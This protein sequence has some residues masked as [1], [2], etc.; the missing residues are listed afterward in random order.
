MLFRSLVQD[1]RVAWWRAA[2]AQRLHGEVVDAMRLADDALADARQ[3]EN[4]KLRSPLDSLRYQR[5]LTENLRL[6]ESI[7]NELATARF[8][9]AALINTP[10]VQSLALDTDEQPG[11]GEFLGQ[12]AQALEEMALA[13][14]ADLREQLYLRRIAATEARKVVAR[15]YPNLT[16]SLGVQHDTDS[17]LIHPTWAEAGLQLGM[18]LLNLLALPAQQATAQASIDVADQRRLAAHV[19]VIAQVHVAREQLGGAQRQFERADTLWQLDSRLAELTAKREQAA[20][21]SKL[22]RV[23]A[24]TTAIVSL[25]RRYQAMAQW[26]AAASRLQATLGVDPLP[27]SSDDLTLDALRAEVRQRLLKPGA[28]AAP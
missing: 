18:N 11:M 10:V 9:L 15:A 25:L 28:K 13:Q 27:Q 24:Q 23:A 16:L 17:Y 6:L 12:S 21:G 8:E 19:A 4:E 22:D 1:V 2:S 26:H 7:Q 20:A 5:Q 3:A 14:N